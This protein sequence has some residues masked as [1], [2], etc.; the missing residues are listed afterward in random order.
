MNSSS[1]QENIYSKTKIKLN[2]Y[3]C[4]SLVNAVSPQKVYIELSVPMMFKRRVLQAD[5][6]PIF[7]SATGTCISY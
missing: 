3:K 7:D 6:W 5:A 4:Y 2:Y 1:N